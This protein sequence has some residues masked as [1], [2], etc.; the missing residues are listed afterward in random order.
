ME[1]DTSRHP[2]DG[3]K[4]PANLAA[5]CHLG[6]WSAQSLTCLLLIPSGMAE[7]DSEGQLQAKARLQQ[8]PACQRCSAPPAACSLPLKRL[9]RS[10]PCRPLHCALA[11]SRSPPRPTGWCSQPRSSGLLSAHAA[12]QGLRRAVLPSPAV[13]PA[14]QRPSSWRRPAPRAQCPT[15]AAAMC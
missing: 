2:P 12:R 6:Q 11:G 14:P 1:V 10:L 15:R 9:P 8:L 3:L 4:F 5:C 7:R 13:P